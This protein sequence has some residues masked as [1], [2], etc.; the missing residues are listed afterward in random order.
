MLTISK[1]KQ[2]LQHF[3][4]RK[5]KSPVTPT[6]SLHLTKALLTYLFFRGDHCEQFGYIS[7][8]LFQLTQTCKN[9][10]YLKAHIKLYAAYYSAT[11]LF[12]LKYIMGQVSVARIYRE[13]NHEESINV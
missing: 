2:A 3:F 8:E 1:Y 12:P 10:P 11:C 9:I 13:Y 6:S 4:K 7:L 5:L